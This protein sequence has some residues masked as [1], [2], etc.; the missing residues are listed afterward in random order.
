[1]AFLSFDDGSTSVANYLLYSEQFDNAAWNKTTGVTITANAATSPDGTNDGD[2][3]V[4]DGTGTPDS[5]R[6]YQSAVAPLAP[7]VAGTAVTVSIWL[8]APTPTT[9][10]IA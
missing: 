5:Y 4:Y 9:V 1:M 6:V 3:I 7:A 8:K 2:F 10:R